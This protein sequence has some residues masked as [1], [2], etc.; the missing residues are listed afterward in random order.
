MARPG[1]LSR[2]RNFFLRAPRDRGNPGHA[3]FQPFR[4]LARHFLA[5]YPCAERG[6]VVFVTAVNGMATDTVL[7]L[8]YFMRE[9]LGIRLLLA[10]ATGGHDGIGTRLG[11]P[12]VPGL[13]DL[14]REDRRSLKE[15]VHPTGRPGI[16]CL[17]AGQAAADGIASLSAARVETMLDEARQSFDFTL[18]QLPAVLED[19]GFL[20]FS[21]GVDTVLLVAV[22]GRT[23]LEDLTRARSLLDGMGAPNVRIVLCGSD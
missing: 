3:A 15:L 11:L 12:G 16:S 18:V 22:E 21:S 14:L 2:L 20:R 10:D 7:T 23:S 5:D 6:R 9:E 17:A 19:P 4:L 8:A 1:L 13:R